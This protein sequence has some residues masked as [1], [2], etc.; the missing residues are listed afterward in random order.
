M[1]EIKE[2]K[3]LNE[4]FAIKDSKARTDI[5]TLASQLASLNTTINNLPIHGN[6]NILTVAKNNSGMFSNINAAI[7]YAATLNPSA[8]NRV[9]ILVFPG[10]YTEK[11]VY[12]GYNYIDV[13]GIARESCV[14]QYSGVY[15]D[16]VI[17]MHGYNRFAN[18]TLKSTSNQ[19]YVIHADKGP[20]DYNYSLEFENCHILGADNALGYGASQGSNVTLKECI[21]EGKVAPVYA[22]NCPYSNKTNQTL[23]LY[24]NIFVANSNNVAIMLDDAGSHYGATNTYL[25]IYA[26]GNSGTYSGFPNLMHRA[27][28]GTEAFDT[29]FIPIS[30]QIIL[31]G[32]CTGNAITALNYGE[33]F[34]SYGWF[35]P[36]PESPNASGYYDVT[37]PTW[38]IATRYYRDITNMT[39]PGVGDITK[40]VSIS[41]V[42][43]HGV[44]ITTTNNLVAGKSITVNMNF[45]V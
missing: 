11:L 5:S 14:I 21:L 18:L 33:G 1:R 4:V 6:L 30:S 28:P 16:C 38:F 39:I 29:T 36:F 20:T 13:I 37:L 19:S 17:H 26:M 24:N 22:H 15:P 40:D 43:E 35:I 10:V 25:R 2:L 42:N 9:T 41:S 3:I 27:H 32:S 34:I 23:E 31:S 12:D 44:T 45:H 8:S 7:A